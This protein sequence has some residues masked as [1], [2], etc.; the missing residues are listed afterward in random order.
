MQSEVHNAKG[1]ADSLVETPTHVYFLEFKL[2]SDAESAL[3]QI[4]TKKYAAPY[5]ADSRIKVGIGINFNSSNKEMT[6]WLM[7]IL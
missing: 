1:R 6:P 4:K 5:A 7:E 2:N 3:Q